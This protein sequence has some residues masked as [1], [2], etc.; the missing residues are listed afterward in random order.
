[1]RREAFS[2]QADPALLEA[3]TR[4]ARSEGRDVEALV[5]EALREYVS[6]HSRGVVREEVVTHYRA[7]VRRNQRLAEL[8]AK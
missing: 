6:R 3:L 8:L 4:V 5:E 7:S 2:F 1:M